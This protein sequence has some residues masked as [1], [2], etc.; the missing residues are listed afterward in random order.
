[1][2]TYNPLHLIPLPPHPTDPKPI[3]TAVTIDPFSDLLWVGTSTGTVSALCSP[4]L[5]T[6]NVRFPAHGSQPN[7]FLGGGMTRGV[8]KIR[9]TDREVWTL[10]EGG[11]S[12]RKRGGAAKWTVSDPTRGLRSMSPNP[13]NSHEVLV[14]GLNGLIVANTIS[15]DTVRRVDI[16]PV[17]WYMLMSGGYV[18]SHC[19]PRTYLSECLL[20]V[21]IGTIID[22]RPE[23]RF[24]GQRQCPTCASAFWWSQW[25]GRA[26]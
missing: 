22:H 5:L 7:V 19:S 13:I 23:N 18:Q 3:P 4:L 12:G 25:G 15:G 8:S 2:T 16:F 1:M 20:C 6:P 14:G 21:V 10:T 17:C 9:V 11:I 24:Q 26:G